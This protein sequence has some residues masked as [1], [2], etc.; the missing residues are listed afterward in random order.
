MEKDWREIRKGLLFPTDADPASCSL[1]PSLLS[2]PPPP[3]PVG[4]FAYD[5]IVV[6]YL[7]SVWE[8]ERSSSNFLGTAAGSNVSSAAPSRS[9]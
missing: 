7:P 1:I 2:P 5:L 3:L 8:N 6:G 9:R 4:E